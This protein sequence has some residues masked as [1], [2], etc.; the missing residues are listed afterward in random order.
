M[1]RANGRASSIWR[2]GLILISASDLTLSAAS[3]E[4]LDAVRKNRKPIPLSAPQ[5][6]GGRLPGL[7]PY[8]SGTMRAQRADWL[9]LG[10]QGPSRPSGRGGGR[11]PHSLG[12]PR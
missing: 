3:H 10:V 2:G 12:R 11:D 6:P 4:L 8:G 5:G 9:G 7:A 1:G